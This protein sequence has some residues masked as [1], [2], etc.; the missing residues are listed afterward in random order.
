MG[1]I[2]LTE[3]HLELLSSKGDCT[4]LSESTL[5]KMPH[6]WNHMSRLIFCLNLYPSLV[7]VQPRKTHPCLTERLFMGRK[8]TNQ[9]NKLFESIN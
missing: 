4:G 3:Y 6:C 5:A 9:T 8:E 2:I 1:V 7:L